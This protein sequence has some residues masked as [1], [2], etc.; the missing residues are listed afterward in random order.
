MNRPRRAMVLLG[1]M[2]V[3]AMA[4][5]AGTTAMYLAQAEL[6]A[7]RTALKRVQSRA[8]AWSGVQAA[9]AEMADQRDKLLDGQSP[10]LTQQWELFAEDGGPRGVIRLTAWTEDGPTAVSESAKLDLNTATAEML[11]KLGLDERTAAAVVAARGKARLASVGDLARVEGF[12]VG[13]LEG[14]GA[15]EAAGGRDP[16]DSLAG[17]SGA[18]AAGRSPSAHEGLGRLVTVF[19]FDPNI[20][21]GLGNNGSDHRGNLRVNLHTEWSDRLAAAMDERFGQGASAGLKAMFDRGVQFKT[22]GDV[23]AAA[24]QAGLPVTG[25]GPIFDALCVSDDPYIIGCV[26]VNRAEATVLAA[27]PGISR[28]AADQIVQIRDKLDAEA[29]R[30]VCWPLVQGVLTAEQ[31][32]QAVDHLTTRSMQWRVRV[33]A[34]FGSAVDGERAA[35]ERLEDRVVLEAVI[36]VASE[37]PRVA[38]LRDV[39]LERAMASV[40][41]KA[42]SVDQEEPAEPALEPSAPVAETPAGPDLGTDLHLSTDLDLSSG[43]DKGVGDLNLGGP[44]AASPID[45]GGKAPVAAAG[46]AVVPGVDRRGGRWAVGSGK[47]A[48]GGTDPRH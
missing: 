15:G 32:G 38:Y 43:M 48:G 28:G 5:L 35:D 4:A 22:M 9:M 7:S 19:S 46:G 36:D 33:E 39:T 11:G 12:D 10:E 21:C 41:A 17:L 20:Q 29:K 13:L 47:G 1:V 34:G 30:T 42:K 37:R 45:A 24:Q 14:T 6:A 2:I 16:G 8:M 44:D 40:Y 26:D 25:W 31:F 18:D 3:I 27:L 23:A